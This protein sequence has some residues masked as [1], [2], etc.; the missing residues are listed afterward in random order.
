MA[1]IKFLIQGKS[2]NTNVYLRL[3]INRNSVF[4]RKTGLTINSKYW[5]KETNYIK[6][7]KDE[8]LKK[9]DNAL[10]KLK[11]KIYEKVNDAIEKGILIDGNWLDNQIDKHFNKREKKDL[12]LLANY[13][14]H[15][16]ESL[17]FKNRSNGDVGLSNRSIQKYKTI[18][19]KVIAFEKYKKK[20]YYL[21]DV[22]AIFRE[23][24]IKF[25]SED[26]DQRLSK[27][28]IG[29]YIPF[30]KTVCRDAKENGYETNPGLGKVK[31]YTTKTKFE[32]LTF[33]EIEK[34]ENTHFTKE[35]LENAKD[36]LIIGCYLGQR[37]SDLL[38]ITKDNLTIVRGTEMVQIIQQKTGKHIAIPLHDK[39]KKILLKRNGEF[40]RKISD[41][42]FNTYIKDVAKAAGIN[43][44]VEGTL[45]NKETK[46]KEEGT[47][48][49]W[50]LVSSHICRRSFASN[51]YGDI[52]TPLLIG[53]TGHSTERQFL[54]YIG[55]PP[56]DKAIQIY[57]YWSLQSSNS[58]ERTKLSTLRKAK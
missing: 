1:T 20:K 19:E 41:Q 44:E 17:P 46:R 13:F 28:T 55:K 25:L 36:W 51:F 57:E 35:S 43:Q 18:K 16:I 26:K 54:E 29:R 2:E 6:Q 27:S 14:D 42:K 47:Y 9:L 15:Y 11:I 21:K 30:I 37:V 5:S 10:Q 23:D 40:P 45:I 56:T 12:E 53:I 4:K 31:G 49:K 50:Q 52:P 48:K 24:F 8:N 58:N 34:I 38:K 32:I 33:D 39:V 22:D 7:N 3:S